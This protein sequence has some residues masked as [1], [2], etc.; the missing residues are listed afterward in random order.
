VPFEAVLAYPLTPF[1]SVL[2]AQFLE[3]LPLLGGEEL[4]ELL[5][6]ALTQALL[7]LPPL[8]QECAQLLLLLR[9]EVQLLGQAFD[10]AVPARFRWRGRLCRKSGRDK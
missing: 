1:L 4:F 10:P 3:L 2:A 9:G 6:E 5:L 8:A 7:L